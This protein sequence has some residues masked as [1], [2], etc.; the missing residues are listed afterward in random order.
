MGGTA[1]GRNLSSRLGRFLYRSSRG[2]PLVAEID[3]VSP[4]EWLLRRFP[5]SHYDSTLLVPFLAAGFDASTSDGEGI[6]LFREFF[7][8]PRI[9]SLHGNK[10]PY[11]I[12]RV[13]ARDVIELGLTIVPTPSEDSCPGHVSI[14]ELRKMHRKT[15]DQKRQQRQFKEDLAERTALAYLPKSFQ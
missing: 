7:L 9:L 10:P 5:Q 13:R 15:I 3:P 14:P 8:S 6:S 4:G 12:G 2:K 1:G 11:V